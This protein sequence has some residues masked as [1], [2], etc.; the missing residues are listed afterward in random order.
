MVGVLTRANGYRS[1]YASGGHREDARVGDTEI[2]IHGN[3]KLVA[4]WEDSSRD[5]GGDSTT[6]RCLLMDDEGHILVTD[7][8][9]AP[10]PGC[11]GS[12]AWDEVIRI[13]ADQAEMLLGQ[14]VLRAETLENYLETHAEATTA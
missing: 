7:Y 2:E 13:S 3:L 14:R 5:E 11:T 10:A 12:V 9:Y 4:Q 1:V 8:S 6:K